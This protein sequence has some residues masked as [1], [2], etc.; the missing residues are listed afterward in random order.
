MRQTRDR[1]RLAR[2][3]S[4]PRPRPRDAEDLLDAKPSDIARL[5]KVGDTGVQANLAT[6]LQRRIGNHAAQGLLQRDPPPTLAPLTDAQQWEADWNAHPDRQNE[7]RGTDRP[8]GTPRQR[9]DVLCPLYKAHGIP[10]PMEYVAASIHTATFYGQTT[11]AH[12]G[13]IPALAAAEKTLRAKG[14]ATAP[15]V[16]M[17]AFNPRTTS[18]GNWSNHADGKA[19]DFDPDTNAR[20]DNKAERNII[21]LVSGTD[22]TT[23]RP[24]YDAMKGASD[25]FKADYNPTGMRRRIT[26]L[27][28]VETTRTTERDTAKTDRDKLKTDLTTA[29]TNLDALNKQLKALPKGKKASPDD[30][31]KAA[32]LNASIKQA[33]LDITRIKADIATKEKDLKK[34]EAALKQATEDR[35]MLDRHLAAFEASD[36]AVADLETAIKPLPAEIKGLE[37]AI[38]QSKLDEAD[39]KKDKNSAGVKAQQQ[40]RATLQKS[41]SAKKAQ[42]AKNQKQLDKKNKERSRDS[43][44]K[45]GAQGFLNL[46]QDFV[47]AMQSAGLTWGGEWGEANSKDFM[48]F[49]E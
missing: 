6:Q 12:D 7:F 19:V 15:F 37:D 3:A 34:K 35:T 42:L 28:A 23:V 41:L 48:H 40:L 44:R 8:T 9:Y 16:S 32:E 21:R 24:G 13:L 4:R 45:Y 26:E 46:S 18:E 5:L 47:E 11:P 49:Q 38:A 10:R 31:T 25:R 20:L 39:A 17:W 43:L 14:Y 2:T 22:M 30:V 27:T 29:K 1:R 36:K 33:N